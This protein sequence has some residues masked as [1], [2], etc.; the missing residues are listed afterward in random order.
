[1]GSFVFLPFMA[2]TFCFSLLFFL[3]LPETKGRAFEEIADMISGK[4]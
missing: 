1:M 2:L 3:K 4:A